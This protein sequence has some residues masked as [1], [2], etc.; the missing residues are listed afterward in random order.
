MS[1]NKTP[2][3]RTFS[4]VYEPFK[5]PRQWQDD[6]SD[7]EEPLESDD[8]DTEEYLDDD[9]FTKEDAR[10]LFVKLDAVLEL[11]KTHLSTKDTSCPQ[12]SSL[13]ISSVTLSD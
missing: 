6:E 5:P 2:F 3:K 11:L 1:T 9:V 7:V 13:V 8:D 12:P 10:P 4:K